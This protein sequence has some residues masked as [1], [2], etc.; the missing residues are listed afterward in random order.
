LWN[1]FSQYTYFMQNFCD[2][3]DNDRL[4]IQDNEAIKTGPVET[5]YV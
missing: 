4:F 2:D 3:V 1:V 5:R